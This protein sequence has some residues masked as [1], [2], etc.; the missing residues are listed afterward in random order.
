[1]EMRDGRWTRVPSANQGTLLQIFKYQNKVK[2]GPTLK[3]DGGALFEYLLV[4]D[5][6]S[7]E[8]WGLIWRKNC[9]YFICFL[10]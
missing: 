2:E 1:M 10:F 5:A 7:E 4:C 6:C 8:N 9:G 3:I